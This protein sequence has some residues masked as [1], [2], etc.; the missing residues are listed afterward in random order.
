MEIRK[1]SAED[2]PYIMQIYKDARTFMKKNGNEEQ[3]GDAY[4][5]QEIV[6]SELDR[7]YLCIEDEEIA[8]VFYYAEE[9]DEDYEKI[10]VSWLNEEPYAVVHRVASTGIVK[11]A[12]ANCINWAYSKTPNLRM[13]TYKDNIPM[14]NL[15]KKCGFQYCGSFERLGMDGWMAYQKV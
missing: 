11:G 8:C 13:D 1:A 5:T 10:H 9:K 12:A 3:W 7:T 15:L 2:F 6:E 14:Q 4:P